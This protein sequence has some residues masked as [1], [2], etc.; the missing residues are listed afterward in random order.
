M[1]SRNI[2]DKI[3]FIHSEASEL[4]LQEMWEI[5]IFQTKLHEVKGLMLKVININTHSL[6][7]LSIVVE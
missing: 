1:N 6:N 3:S 2:F 7:R 4:S 5:L